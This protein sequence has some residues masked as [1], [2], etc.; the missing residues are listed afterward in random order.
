MP[1]VGE[2][3]ACELGR[4]SNDAEILPLAVPQFVE[5][6]LDHAIS[7]IW[8]E[9]G[10][11]DPSAPQLAIFV[12]EECIFV[13]GPGFGVEIRC[14]VVDPTFAALAWILAVHLICDCIPV[15]IVDIVDRVD[16][17]A[18]FLVVCI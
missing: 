2:C 12:H 6:V 4:W 13:G 18:Q 5:P 10:D 11:L 14:Q 15:D 9:V 7:A 8:E 17:T 3:L 16:Q 1:C